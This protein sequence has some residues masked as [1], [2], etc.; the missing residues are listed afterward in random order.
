MRWQVF[1]P[2]LERSVP[3]EGSL[4]DGCGKVAAH[5]EL[6]RVSLRIPLRELGVCLKECE[7]RILIGGD[8]GPQEQ[9]HVTSLKGALPALLDMSRFP[10]FFAVLPVYGATT[11]NAPER[12]QEGSRRGDRLTPML[13]K[14]EASPRMWTQTRAIT[15]P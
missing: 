9:G 12:G 15:K 11:T 4:S 7:R 10:I 14:R 8:P 3:N 5:T 1:V 6:A 13:L 2:R